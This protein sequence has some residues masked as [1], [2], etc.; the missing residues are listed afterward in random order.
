MATKL[1]QL[2]IARLR[3]MLADTERAAGAKSVSAEIIR[4][5]LAAKLAKQP[6]K[7]G[8]ARA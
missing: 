6:A 3:Q 4:Q 5:A 2:S 1:S 8:N 7:G